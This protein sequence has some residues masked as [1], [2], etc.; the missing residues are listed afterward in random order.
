MQL[1]VISLLSSI[2]LV[3]DDIFIEGPCHH[4]TGLRKKERER[5]RERINIILLFSRAVCVQVYIIVLFYQTSIY[6]A[7]ISVLH[8]L[9]LCG[10]RACILI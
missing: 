10:V 9:I 7:I 8:V 2:L 5:E 6:M 1:Q 4:L 3:V